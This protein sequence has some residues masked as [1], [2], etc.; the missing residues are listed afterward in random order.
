MSRTCKRGHANP[1]RYKRSG[2][3][4][5]CEKERAA[6]RSASPAHCEY[7]RV[8]NA[9]RRATPEGREDNRARSAAKYATQE[10]REYAL[11]YRAAFYATPEGRERVRVQNAARYASPGG[12]E[13]ALARN[14]AYRATPDGRMSRRL[15]RARWR[16]TLA[17][18]NWP[19]SVKAAVRKVYENCPLG[20][21]V[22]HII[23]LRGKGVCGLHVPWNL[24]YLTKSENSR[25]SN[26]MEAVNG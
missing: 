10:G 6:A 26:R 15:E 3:C 8:A 19:K 12:K 13:K 24:Q 11:A 20:L 1:Q 16:A 25:K 14:A 23:P 7:Q 9:T 21:V 4:V 2:N 5:A 17:A 18:Q 22:D